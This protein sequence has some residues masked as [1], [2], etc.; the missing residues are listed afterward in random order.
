MM[1]VFW[2]CLTAAV[3]M[4]MFMGGRTKSE[5]FL[6]RLFVGRSKILWGKHVHTFHQ[7]GGIMVAIFGLLIA[8]GVIPMK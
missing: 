4:V 5:F 7:V 1:P 3:G 2:G 8:F 6:Y